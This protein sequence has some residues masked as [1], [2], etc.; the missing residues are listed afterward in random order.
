MEFSSKK[1]MRKKM[2]VVAI[3]P[4]KSKSKRVKRKNFRVVGG[5]PLYKHLLGKLKNTTFDEIYVDSDSAEIQR[6]CYKNGYNFIKR[7]PYLAKDNAN[8]NDLLNYH[9]S[10]IK[11][12]IYFQLFIT[13]PLLKVKTINQCIKFLKNNKKYDSILTTKSIYSWFWF[14][15]KPVN[16]N[17]QILPRS[18]D[19]FPIV[20]ET[21]GLYGI[22]RKALEKN[23]CR[24]GKKPFFFEVSDEECIDLDNNKDFKYFE[25]ILKKKRI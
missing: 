1:E 6:Y 13:S 22:K 10:I 18:Q 19:A 23:K 2:K 12:D 5:K 11:A 17:P 4:I 25:F 7:L 15:K 21:T 8:G 20:N 9:K 3:I 14:K 24:I 16:Y